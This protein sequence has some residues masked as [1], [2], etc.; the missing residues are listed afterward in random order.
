MERKTV[1]MATNE[2]ASNFAAPLLKKCDINF[3]LTKNLIKQKPILTKLF[4]FATKYV[5]ASESCLNRTFLGP[6]FV[7]TIHSCLVYTG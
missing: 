6:T 7:F 3:N 5:I 4:I 2:I 1:K